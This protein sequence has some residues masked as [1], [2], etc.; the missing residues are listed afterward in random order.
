M[1]VFRPSFLFVIAIVAPKADFKS[2]VI[3]LTFCKQKPRNFNVVYYT[4]FETVIILNK[5]R[6]MTKKTALKNVDKNFRE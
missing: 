5:G 3:V 4:L 1:G 2:R 6:K